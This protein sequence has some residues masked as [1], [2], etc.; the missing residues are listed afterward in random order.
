MSS[1]RHLQWSPVKGESVALSS[2]GFKR[3][4][5]EKRSS[6]AAF[7]LLLLPRELSLL[8]LV[9]LV[10][11]FVGFLF[12]RNDV[13]WMKFSVMVVVFSFFAF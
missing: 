5:T 7:C 11:L 6:H 1:P 3:E 4:E 10:M 9:V 12:D 13:M 2:Q 8:G